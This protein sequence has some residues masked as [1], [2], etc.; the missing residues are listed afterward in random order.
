MKSTSLCNSVFVNVNIFVHRYKSG[1]G[2]FQRIAIW[3]RE[4][5]FYIDEKYLSDGKNE[6]EIMLH[7]NFRYR[8]VS[9]RSS[10]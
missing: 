4:Q 10:K 3:F 2:S 9:W 8:F 6:R 1:L 5:H 7:A